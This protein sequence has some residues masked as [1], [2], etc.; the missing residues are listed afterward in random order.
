M[1]LVDGH[2]KPAGAFENRIANR[3][4]EH[5]TSETRARAIGSLASQRAVYPQTRKAGCR[6]NKLR[7]SSTYWTL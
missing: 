1:V 4:H 5:D 3:S 7:H 2:A 6:S